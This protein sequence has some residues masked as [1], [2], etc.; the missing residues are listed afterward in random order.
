[1]RMRLISVSCDFLNHAVPV[2]YPR[3]LKFSLRWSG[4]KKGPQVLTIGTAVPLRSLMV[5]ISMVLAM[6]VTERDSI[7]VGGKPLSLFGTRWQGNHNRRRSAPLRITHDARDMYSLLADKTW[8]ARVSFANINNDVMSW[9][10]PAEKRH[11][12]GFL[13]CR[14]PEMRPRAA[15]SSIV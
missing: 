3:Y 11:S 9:V 5:G 10:R 7:E 4:L 15:P 6:V 14:V 1:M 8:T 2:P 12:R 13:V